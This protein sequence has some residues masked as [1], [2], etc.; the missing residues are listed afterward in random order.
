MELISLR[1][2]LNDASYLVQIAGNVAVA[3]YVFPMWRKLRLRFLLVFGLAALLNVF[4]NF[5]ALVLLRQPP[6]IHFE[7]CWQATRFLWIVDLIL[8]PIA[9]LMMVRHFN[10]PTKQDDS[11]PPRSESVPPLPPST[12]PSPPASTPPPPTIT[13]TLPPSR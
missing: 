13:I 6:D 12:P 3:Y 9:I 5:I 11:T 2:I 4:V 1:E 7:W 8:F 10:T